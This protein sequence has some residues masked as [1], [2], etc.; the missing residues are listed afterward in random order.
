MIADQIVLGG[1]LV[2]ILVVI[3]LLLLIFGVAR[4]VL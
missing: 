2:T 3:L 4:K 1:D